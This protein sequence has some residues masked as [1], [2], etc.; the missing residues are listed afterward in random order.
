MSLE[1][2]VRGSLPLAGNLGWGSINTNS[3][4]FVNPIR[5]PLGAG[6]PQPRA[7][8]PFESLLENTA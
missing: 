5:A 4:L 2:L 8:L 6:P 7:L 3:Q 1:S